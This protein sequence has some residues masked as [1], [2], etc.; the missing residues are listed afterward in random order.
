[1]EFERTGLEDLIL[2]LSH[3]FRDKIGVGIGKEWDRSHERSTIIVDYILER[4]IKEA[5]APPLL[6]TLGE[7]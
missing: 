4:N 3:H 1:M 6:F 2:E 5:I 7:P